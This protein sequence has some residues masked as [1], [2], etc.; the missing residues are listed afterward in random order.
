[1][2]RVSARELRKQSCKG[3]CVFMPPLGGCE[4]LQYNKTYGGIHMKHSRLLLFIP[5]LLAAFLAF[6]QS[7]EPELV[8]VQAWELFKAQQGETWTVRWNERT[9]VP[10][11]IRNGRSSKYSGTAEQ[12]AQ[13]FLSD[14]RTV[15]A[16]KPGLPDL[17]YTRTHENRYGVKRVG[18]Q[19][20][21]EAIRVYGAT[22]KVQVQDGR[23]SMVN[24]FY[25]PDIEESTSPAVSESEAIRTAR[26][27]LEIPP[28]QE[29]DIQTELVIWPGDEQF[30]LGWKLLLTSSESMIGWEFILDAHSGM[31]LFRE[32]L[33]LQFSTTGT[34]NIYPTHPDISSVTTKDL[35]RLNGDGYLNG[36]F[37]E[38]E[39]DESENAFSE[40]HNFQYNT[41]STHFDEVNVYYHVDDFHYNFIR[42]LLLSEC[43]L[44]MCGISLPKITA[45]VNWIVP[46]NAMYNSWYQSIHFG[47]GSGHT[48]LNSF[49]REDKVIYH[50]F[51]H[52]VIDML[53]S[54]AFGG[55]NNEKGAINEGVPD[56]L[57]GAYSGRSKFGDYAY[58]A[59]QRDMA[60][61][62]FTHYDNLEKNEEGKSKEPKYLG[63][64]F[65]SAVLW[66]LRNS[67]GIIEDRADFL[68]IDAISGLSSQPDFLEFR[69]MMMAADE[70]Y[71]NA[72]N[73]LIQN[74]FADRGI[75][76]HTP[77]SDPFSATIW[78]E[79]HFGE[80]NSGMWWATADGGISPYSYTWF[81]SYTSSTGT[82][83]QVGTGS[84]YSQIVNDEMWLR[85]SV[86]DSDC[87]PFCSV[88]ADT[89]HIKVNTCANP[90]CP[91]PKVPGGGETVP[92]AF[93]L[94][95]NYPNPFNPATTIRYDL[96]EHSDVR[97]EVFNMLGQRVALLVDGQLQPGSHTAV[98]DASNL[99]SGT[100]LLQLDAQ[101]GSGTRFNRTMGM[102]LVK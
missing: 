8:P 95:Q 4:H 85:L 86:M 27:G 20:Y 29:L 78:G 23:V 60:N 79:T 3:R 30:H 77:T 74:T 76:S 97:M 41:S 25:Y 64:E 81:R 57:A 15:F 96:P 22:L 62:F 55:G 69:D 51:G 10:R 50:E 49:A 21:A 65:F 91:M 32:N 83:T 58:P 101:G 2:L 94:S 84:S 31:E 42:S 39:N 11:T 75:G 53:N 36:L 33:W 28:E 48:E 9:G 46:E 47:N 63:A 71:N 90:P 56:Y 59:K 19:Q 37:V 68:V 40:S 7:G 92:E 1:M 35:Y 14:Y 99:S 26:T 12:V 5:L 67:G 34:G 73:D 82:W 89:V 45:H 52:F 80:G 54:D 38:V 61:P 88:T 44:L 43:G 98:F 100:Y 93:A 87:N 16:M 17:Q 72:H 102:Q 24:G 66:D 70:V 18:F 6:S 13:A